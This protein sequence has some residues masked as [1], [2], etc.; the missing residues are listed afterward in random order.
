M[1]TAEFGDISIRTSVSAQQL[2]A[3]IAVDHGG[4]GQAIS[5]HI[6]TMQS[7]LG[8]DSGLQTS[9]EVRHLGSSLSGETGQ[10]SQR[11]QRAFNY[12]GSAE[13]ASQTTEEASGPG[14]GIGLGAMAAVGDGSRL[15]IRA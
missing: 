13:S 5:A 14:M 6:S 3:Q 15:D 4:L 8:E 2:V 9:I 11:E 7:K 10:S 12:G 1:R